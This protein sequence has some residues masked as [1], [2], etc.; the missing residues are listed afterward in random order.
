MNA[1]QSA[2]ITAAQAASSERIGYQQ[3]IEAIDAAQFWL[4]AIVIVIGVGVAIVA[5]IVA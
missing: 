5:L 1:R 3:Q 2:H 4:R